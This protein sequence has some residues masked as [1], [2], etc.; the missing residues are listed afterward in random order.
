VTAVKLF[1]RDPTEQVLPSHHLKTGTSQF[2]KAVL[3]SYVGFR[4]LDT[5]SNYELFM[6]IQGT[7]EVTDRRRQLCITK[8]NNNYSSIYNNKRAVITGN[9]SCIKQKITHG[10]I[11]PRRQKGRHHSEDLRL[12]GKFTLGRS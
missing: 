3:S 2:L 6:T 10:Y 9:V 1:L 4:K 11:Q 5:V 12:E 8:L 7:E